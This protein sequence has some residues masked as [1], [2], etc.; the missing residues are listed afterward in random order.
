LP[1][2]ALALAA[3]STS[4]P[5]PAPAASASPKATAIAPAATHAPV[6]TVSAPAELPPAQPAEAVEGQTMVLGNNG[7]A[8]KYFTNVVLVNQDNTSMRFYADLIRGKIVIINAFFSRC[9]A[10]CPVISRAFARIQEHL[11]A[12]VGKDVHIVSI[13]VDPLHDT[14]ERLKK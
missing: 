1:A 7:G 10:S 9:G 4:P 14:P 12:R 11:G 8:E 13:S 3:C 5:E 2:L 6:T